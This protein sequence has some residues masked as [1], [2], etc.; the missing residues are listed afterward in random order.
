MIKT[1]IFKVF[2]VS[3]LCL[4][5][6]GY[7]VMNAASYQLPAISILGCAL[8]ERVVEGEFSVVMFFLNT[9]KGNTELIKAVVS[10]EDLA[11]GHTALTLAAQHGHAKIIEFLYDLFKDDIALLK[12]FVMHKTKEGNTA[13]MFAS[14][15]GKEDVV[16]AIVAPFIKDKKTLK[17]IV[18]QQHTLPNGCLAYTALMWA[19]HFRHEKVCLVLLEPFFDDLVYARI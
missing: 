4:G 1:N 17:E 9:I 3:L 10:D 11:T 14:M 5:S 16:R 19:I 13:L 15:N 7:S 2:L 6:F 8:R 12:K 18:K